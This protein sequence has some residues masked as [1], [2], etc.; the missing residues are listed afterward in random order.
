MDV[1]TIIVGILSFAGTLIGTLG[2]IIASSKLTNY[3]L[4]Q[5]EHKVELH[6]NAV[7]RLYKAEGNIKLN[8]T[9][10][11]DLK[12]EIHNMKNT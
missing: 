5:L 7:E 11:S 6:N 12:Q 1:S 2:G 4:Q 9:E 8:S 3:R 10:I